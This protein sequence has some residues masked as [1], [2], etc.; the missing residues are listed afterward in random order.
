MLIFIPVVFF[1]PGFSVIVDG[2]IVLRSKQ[3]FHEN[4]DFRLHSTILHFYPLYGHFR[5]PPSLC[6]Y[7]ICIIFDFHNILGIFFKKT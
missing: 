4:N 1:L 7:V 3:T 6:Q 5:K 2:T